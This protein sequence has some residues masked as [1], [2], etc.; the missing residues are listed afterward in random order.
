MPLLSKTQPLPPAPSKASEPESMAAYSNTYENFLNKNFPNG[1][2]DGK[3]QAPEIDA[4]SDVKV[5]GKRP[6][7][8]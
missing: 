4:V 5:P 8:K 2:D 1:T 3:S 6:R 7:S